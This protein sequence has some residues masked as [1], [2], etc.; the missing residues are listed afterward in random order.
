MR[1]LS[2]TSCVAPVRSVH[3]TWMRTDLPRGSVVSST[4]RV[5]V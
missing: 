3:A 2:S 1:V 4:Q 5:I